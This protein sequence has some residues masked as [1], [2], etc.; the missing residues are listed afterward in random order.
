MPKGYKRRWTA[1]VCLLLCAAL[2]GYV[3][4]CAGWRAWAEAEPTAEAVATPAPEMQGPP[5]ATRNPLALDVV[6]TIPPM[7]R[8]PEPE[9][10]PR[11]ARI[12]AV[13]DLM[14][15]E[16]QLRIARQEDGSYDFH[17][18]YELVADALANADYTIANLETTVGIYGQMAYSGYPLFNAPEALLEAVGDCGVDFLTLANNHM[19]DRYFDGLKTT[20]DR[21]EEYGF[22]HGGANRTQAEHDAPVIVE[23][24][25]IRLGMICCTQMTNGMEEFCNS[26]AR[27]YGINYMSDIDFAAEVKR[28]RENGA[29]VVICLPHWGEEYARQPEDYVVTYARRMIRAGVDVVLASHPHMVQPVKWVTVETE[30]GETRTGLVAYCLGNFISNMLKRYTDSGIILEFTLREQEDGTFAIEDVGYLPIY[31]WKQDNMI[32]A[33]CSAK[34]IDERPA[35]MSADT[36]ARLTASRRELRELLGEDLAVLAE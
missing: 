27:E 24:N 23:V 34:Y 11:T 33:V 6:P 26:A 25:G 22:A 15:H 30:D 35:G 31:C 21:V 3:G 14:M 36:Y 1:F 2:A 19:L 4:L 18:Q 29:D 12:R 13:G 28:L 10:A 7:E 20:V 5:Q 17:P 8:A 16:K 32:R 9:P